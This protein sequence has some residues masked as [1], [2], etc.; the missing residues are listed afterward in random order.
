MQTSTIK[1]TVF[2]AAIYLSIVLFLN[3]FAAEAFERIDRASRAIETIQ[4][5]GQ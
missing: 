3:Y 5:K 2:N 1:R 4:A